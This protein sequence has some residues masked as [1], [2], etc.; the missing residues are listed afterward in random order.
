MNHRVALPTKT[1]LSAKRYEAKA[2]KQTKTATK[3]AT[4]TNHSAPSPTSARNTSSQNWVTTVV[5]ALI[6]VPHANQHSGASR[7]SVRRPKKLGQLCE[8][9]CEGE[10][11]G[12]DGLC[13]EGTVCVPSSTDSSLRCRKLGDKSIKCD[14]RNVGCTSHEYCQDEHC[15]RRKQ[16]GES[17]IGDWISNCDTNMLCSDGSCVRHHASSFAGCTR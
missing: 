4:T 14:Y 13:E 17:C 1:G 6:L 11:V 15:V 3:R 2:A 10:L 9:D 16:R 7:T 8:R 12:C 5:V